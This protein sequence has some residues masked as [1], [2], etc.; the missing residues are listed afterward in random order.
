MLCPDYACVMILSLSQL[1]HG[2]WLKEPM[3]LVTQKQ[4]DVFRLTYI[5]NG[6][7]GPS[8]LLQHKLHYVVTMSS[9]SNLG[10][11]IVNGV[12]KHIIQVKADKVSSKLS[13]SFYCVFLNLTAQRS[14]DRAGHVNELA[15]WI[16]QLWSNV[17]VKSHS[18]KTSSLLPSLLHHL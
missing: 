13:H 2:I 4:G 1:S 8:F 7:T 9:C 5:R 18:I 17:S 12:S 16:Q 11:Y 3:D 14:F 6:T 15:K 10:L